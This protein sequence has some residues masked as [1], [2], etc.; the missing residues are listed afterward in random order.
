MSE[1]AIAMALVVDANALMVVIYIL[2]RWTVPGIRARRDL[3]L[4]VFPSP[5]SMRDDR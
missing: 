5:F 2:A 4:T 3:P 1:S